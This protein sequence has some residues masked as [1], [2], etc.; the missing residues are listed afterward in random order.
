[1]GSIAAGSLALTLAAT[2]SIHSAL[3]RLFQLGLGRAGPRAGAA[4][5]QQSRL[6]ARSG[7]ASEMVRRKRYRT[8]R[9]VWRT[10]GRSTRRSSRCAGSRSDGFCRRCGPD[11]T[12]LMDPRRRCRTDR[13]G[14][15]ARAGLLRRQRQLA[16]RASLAILRPGALALVPPQWNADRIR[17]HSATSA[18]S[19]P[20]ETIGHSINI[21][22]LSADDAARLNRVAGSSS[23]TERFANV[24]SSST[25]AAYGRRKP[26]PG[27]R[28]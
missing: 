6:G 1:M 12:M 26:E 7:R 9:S 8:S 11:T 10:S 27:H 15:A 25:R 5:R 14:A 17:T 13:P 2:A 20:I 24:R 21:Y 18:S 3:P 22:R 16:L 23:R 28:R 4:D 19:G